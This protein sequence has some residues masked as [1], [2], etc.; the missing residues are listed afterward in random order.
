LILYGSRARGTAHAASDWD[1]AYEADAAFDP[2]GLLAGLAPSTFTPIAST[3][4]IS[5][6]DGVHDLTGPENR[7][8]D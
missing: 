5:I 2:D 4:S 6:A 8:D 1:F 7:S 3:S